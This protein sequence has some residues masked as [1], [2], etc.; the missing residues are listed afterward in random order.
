LD[1][2]QV[3]DVGVQPLGDRRDVT[4][5]LVELDDAQRF[6]GPVVFEQSLETFCGGE[7]FEGQRALAAF[8]ARFFWAWMLATT[9][10]VT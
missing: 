4:A 8:P 7:V 1:T 2:G 6:I 5:D 10:D 3:V 9:P